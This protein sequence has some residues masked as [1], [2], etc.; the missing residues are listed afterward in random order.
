MRFI[1]FSL[2][3]LFIT[4][5]VITAQYNFVETNRISCTEVKSQDRTGTCWSFATASFIESELI[6]QGK[7]KHDLSEMFVVR[8][9][10]L[11]KARNYLLRQG[12]ANLSQGSLAHD[13]IRVAASEGV[14][15]ES[16][17]SGLLPGNE[18]HDHNEMEAV[19]KA[20]MD[21]IISQ[22]RPSDKWDDVLNAILDVYLGEA[23][24]EF[25][26]E[27]KI[28]EPTSFAK[29]LDLDL[30]DYFSF[31]SF[32]HHPY[33]KDFILEI[34]DNYSNGSYLN[35]PLRELQL[36]VDNALN[37][38][39]SISWDGDVSEAGFKH[40]NGIAVLPIDSKD[41]AFLNNPVDEISVDAEKRQAAFENFS[42]TDDHLMHL[43]GTAKDKNGDKYYIIKNSWGDKNVYQGY[44]YMS[45]AYLLM[46]T[47]SIMVHKD[48]VPVDIREKCD[49]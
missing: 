46:K 30:E 44:L 16:I 22:K 26:Y 14:V 35:L 40:A 19:I 29:S 15:P 20:S 24:S 3:L 2:M 41:K 23:P 39:F 49:L 1:C 4:S 48:A 5:T 9:I 34:P 38:G 33:Y 42:T 21:A 31:S 45:E 8:N 37:S 18:K 25:K 17:Y 6:R 47:V 27:G 12:K 13:L 7:G 10:Y 36:I 11:D 43:I 28:Y 32:T